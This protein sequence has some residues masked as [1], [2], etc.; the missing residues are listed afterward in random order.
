[1]NCLHFV[2]TTPH[3][4]ELS[5]DPVAFGEALFRSEQFA[6]FAKPPPSSPNQPSP[7]PRNK[8][9]LLTFE[10]G[11]SRVF[12]GATPPPYYAFWHTAKR[13]MRDFVVEFVKN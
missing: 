5:Y 6:S 9:F 2:S 10:D 7:L 8:T 1:M 3:S 11:S 13:E 4:K 12:R